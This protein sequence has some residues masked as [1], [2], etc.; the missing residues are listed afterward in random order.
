[1]NAYKKIRHIFVFSFIIILT[2][3]GISQEFM[4]NVQV[5][6]QQ[7]EGTDKRVFENMQTAITEFIN[8]RRWTNYDFEPEER[9]ECS[10]VIAITD[11]PSPDR[12]KAT[13]NIVA[14]RPV[15]KTSY[16]STLLNYAD[17]KFEFNYVEFQPMEFQ[18]NT[19]NSNLT[20]VIAYYLYILLAFDFDSFSLFGGT[21]YFTIAENIVNAAQNS[22]ESGWKAFEDPNNRYWLLE[23][24]M[25]NT[26]S[27]LRKFLYEYHRMGL[28]MMPDDATKGRENIFKSLGYLKSVYDEKPGLF[29]LQLLVDAKRDEIVNV[30]SEGNPKEIEE[31]QNIMNEID[32]ANSSTYSKIGQRK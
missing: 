12:F 13:L 21:P 22:P 24:Y 1:M 23:N 8:S 28:D 29:A 27:G 32:P 25:N 16:T 30:F 5:N 17:K 10:I 31:T 19:Y 11:R 9:L 2:F 26:Y 6:S 3:P 14:S 20:S 15:F 4:C 7:I 18:E